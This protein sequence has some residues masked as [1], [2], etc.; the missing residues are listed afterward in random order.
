MIDT[1]RLNGSGPN[2]TRARESSKAP[3]NHTA[4]SK[5]AIS[6]GKTGNA[7]N[8]VELSQQAQTISRMETDIRSSPEVNSAKVNAIKTAIAEGRFEI[9]ADAIAEKMLQQ[10]SLLG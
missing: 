10:E 3:G 2:T 6:D 8:N 7:N 5:T 4:P 1:N 9:N